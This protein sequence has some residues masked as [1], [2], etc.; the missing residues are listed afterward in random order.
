M[1]CCLRATGGSTCSTPGS[2]RSTGCPECTRRS[3]WCRCPPSPTRL[4]G[5]WRSDAHLD[6]PRPGLARH[7]RQPDPRPRRLDPRGGRHLLLVRREQGALDAG[8]RHLALGRALLLLDRPVQLDRPRPDHPA[9]RRR[10]DVAAAPGDVDGPAA[11]PPSS[12]RPGSSSAG[13]RSCRP[14]GQRSTVLVADDILG[15]YRVV[16]ARPQATRH[17]RRRLRPRRR[18]RP[19]ARATTTS[20]GCT[21]S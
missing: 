14:A 12:R 15:P 21:A 10:P 6:H 3:C 4:S 20:S 13:S 19:T 7:R 9:R 8:Q 18:S 5:W 1:F 17:E 2:A 16:R 11:H